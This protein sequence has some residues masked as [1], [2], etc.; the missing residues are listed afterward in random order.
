MNIFLYFLIFIL[1]SFTAQPQTKLEK[2]TSEI[3]N[4]WGN[5]ILDKNEIDRKSVV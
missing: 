1:F 3:S 2:L 4:L 5:A